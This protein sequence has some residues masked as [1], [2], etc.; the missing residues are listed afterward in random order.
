M[1]HQCTACLLFEEVP[2]AH[3]TRGYVSPF[4]VNFCPDTP[5][6]P[7]EAGGGEV[8]VVPPPGV[9]VGGGTVV[10]GGGVVV[11]GT[12]VPGMHWE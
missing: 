3:P 5:T 11:G 4:S 6:K 12:L 10:V 7:V 9:D 8:V 1:R 2:D